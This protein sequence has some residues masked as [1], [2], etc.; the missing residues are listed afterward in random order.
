MSVARR[1]NGERRGQ[2]A[3]PRGTTAA[4]AGRWMGR[5]LRSRTPLAQRHSN[6]YS[7]TCKGPMTANGLTS[8]T[9]SNIRRQTIAYVP[10]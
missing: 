3:E 7:S 5:R 6:R 8:A 10:D 9:V 4:G 2:V 1:L